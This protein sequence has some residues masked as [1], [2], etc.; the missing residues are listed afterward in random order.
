MEREAALEGSL[1]QPSAG[2]LDSHCVRTSDSV[3]GPSRGGEKP[4]AAAAGGEGIEPSAGV[5]ALAT[6]SEAEDL[7]RRIQ[8]LTEKLRD[9]K[10]PLGA[11]SDDDRELVETTVL[12]APALIT[13][14]LEMELQSSV[15]LLVEEGVRLAAQDLLAEAREIV[16]TLTPGWSVMLN[17]R[18][19][20]LQSGIEDVQQRARQYSAEEPPQAT[21]MILT[22]I[23]E[24]TGRVKVAKEICACLKSF[25]QPPF[26][27][28]DLD[29]PLASFEARATEAEET[30]R[31]VV[32]SL[33]D[34]WRSRLI[35]LREAVDSGEPLQSELQE[36]EQQ[37]A[38]AVEAIRVISGFDVDLD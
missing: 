21:S 15:P 7:T 12:E 14:G 37:A 17:L 2:S 18:K 16:A 29:I 11:P 27:A 19:N 35:A 25:T 30:A 32:N 4:L 1:A 9:L 38:A 10:N 13:T 3:S 6:T 26:D 31:S 8:A 22:D 36:A 20:L 28:E 5:A 33:V 34:M 23:L 24:L